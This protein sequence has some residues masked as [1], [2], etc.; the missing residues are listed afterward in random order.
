MAFASE[1]YV[2]AVRLWHDGDVRMVRGALAGGVAVLGYM[3]VETRAH[4]T[5]GFRD[6]CAGYVERFNTALGSCDCD[7]KC[8][9]AEDQ[10]W[11]RPLL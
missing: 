7:E 2:L 10:D 1:F 4:A 6:L 11:L 9:Q 5:E 8:R 3:N